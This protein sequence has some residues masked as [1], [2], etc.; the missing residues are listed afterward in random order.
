MPLRPAPRKRK[1]LRA[2]FC[3]AFE[4]KLLFTCR[5]SAKKTLKSLE[6]TVQYSDFLNHTRLNTHHIYFTTGLFVQLTR[7]N[8]ESSNSPFTNLAIKVWQFPVFLRFLALN[9][10]GKERNCTTTVNALI[11]FPCLL[12]SR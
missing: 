3:D 12:L 5:I 10:A 4:H 9:I 11:D 1:L 8:L 2:R 6:K 7:I